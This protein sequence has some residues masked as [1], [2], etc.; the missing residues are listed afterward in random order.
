MKK[1]LLLTV[2]IATAYTYLGAQEAKESSLREVELVGKTSLY[3]IVGSYGTEEERA[4]HSGMIVYNTTVDSVLTKGKYFWDG[5]QWNAIPTVKANR[6]GRLLS[7]ENGITLSNQHLTLGGTLNKETSIAQNSFDMSTS[8]TG[9]FEIQNDLMYKG[10][11]AVGHVLTAS[12]SD[13]TVEWKPLPTPTVTTVDN[14]LTKVGDNIVLGGTLVGNT[15]INQGTFDLTSNGTGKLNVNN[16]LIYK[17]TATIGHVLTASDANGTVEWKTLPVPAATTASNGLT[18]T[19]NDINLGGSLT[20]TVVINQE[21][22]DLT[23]NGTGKLKVINDMAYKTSSTKGHVLTAVDAIGTVA[24]QA[25]PAYV[26]TTASNGL[27][28]TGNDISLGGALAKAAAINQAALDLTINGTGK[29]KVTNDLVYKTA[30]VGHVLTANDATGTVVWQAIPTTGNNGL[31]KSGNA[32]QFGGGLTK[33]TTI[34]QA[35]LQLNI[36][37]TGNNAFNVNRALSVSADKV[38]IGS[39]LVPATAAILDIKNV[40]GANGTA[41]STVGGVLLPRVILTDN[42]SL[43]PFIA[44]G[45]SVAEKAAHKGLLVYHIGGSNIGA[46]TKIWDGIQWSKM[47]TDLDA[48]EDIAPQIYDL[49]TSVTALASEP[50]ATHLAGRGNPLPIGTKAA[51]GKYYINLEESG[52]YVFAVKFFGNSTHRTENKLGYTRAC[53]YLTLMVNGVKVDVQEFNNNVYPN[54]NQ[55]YGTGLLSCSNVA[56]GAKVQ[57]LLSYYAAANNTGGEHFAKIVQL[58]AKPT[59]TGGDKTSLTYWKL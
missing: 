26:V 35:A 21:A 4:R 39:Q 18:K 8:G 1:L 57:I 49:Q 52:S 27:T 19:G 48:D 20:K 40:E 30:T 29:L 2:L 31:A 38:T 28:K 32:L 36:T 7:G 54:S 33:A 13:G 41:T 10:T 53:Y 14:G 42:R 23:L 43:K 37:S 17:G 50:N 47:V 51:D 24:W 15:T 58:V 46:G 34:A 5:E 59:S 12:A 9:I 11:A 16:D 44:S 56:A 55:L 6:S 3:P 25:L 22:L 45:G